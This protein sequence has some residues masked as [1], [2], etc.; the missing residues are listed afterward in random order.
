MTSNKRING[1]GTKLQVVQKT[2]LGRGIPE[3]A[4]E[5]VPVVSSPPLTEFVM[6]RVVKSDAL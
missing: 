5:S 3:T 1:D 4:S 6:H 2:T